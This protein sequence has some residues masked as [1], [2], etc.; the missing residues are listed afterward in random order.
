VNDDV[1]A[2]V[3]VELLD[4]LPIH[5]GEDRELYIMIARMFYPN[6]PSRSAQFPTLTGENGGGDTKPCPARAY[7]PSE[8]FPW[9]FSRHCSDGV[10]TTT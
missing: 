7:Q 1:I 5:T 6:G 10:C 8:F 9:R 3:V 2:C 4:P